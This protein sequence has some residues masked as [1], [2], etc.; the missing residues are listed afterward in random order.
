MPANIEL[1]VRRKCAAIEYLHRC[2]E[3]WRPAPLQDHR[4]LLREVM[5]ERS[6]ARTARQRQFDQLVRKCGHGGERDAC[7][8][9]LPKERTPRQTA[10]ERGPVGM[11]MTGLVLQT[12]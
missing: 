2:F 12:S 8:A 6:F 4:A 9:D 3:Q 11:A 10:S 5:D 7:N 1:I